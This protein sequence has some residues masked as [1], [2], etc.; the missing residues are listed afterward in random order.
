MSSQR[1]IDSS[2][3]NGARSHGPVT[4]EGG[5]IVID[6]E[7]MEAQLKNLKLHEEPNR[8]KP[9]HY[10]EDR[11]AAEAPKSAIVSSTVHQ[12]G[13]RGDERAAELKNQEL[14]P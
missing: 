13:A 9:P 6:G 14:S 1:R 11:D 3:V 7:T 2:R 10:D 12:L 4:P 5:A 8:A